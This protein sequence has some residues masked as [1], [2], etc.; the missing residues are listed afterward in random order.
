LGI[1]H[2]KNFSNAYPAGSAE[3]PDLSIGQS[4]VTQ[5]WKK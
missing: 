2:V 3:T 4:G 5:G 1:V